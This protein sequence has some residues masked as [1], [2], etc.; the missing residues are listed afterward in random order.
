MQIVLN[1]V[2]RMPKCFFVKKSTQARIANHRCEGVLGFRQMLR[3]RRARSASRA[4]YLVLQ[5]RNLNFRVHTDK[6]SIQIQKTIFNDVCFQFFVYL[7]ERRRRRRDRWTN[8]LG[9]FGWRGTASP[10]LFFLLRKTWQKF[11]F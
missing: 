7:Q 1:C 11:L 4:L 2:K 9:A 6:N 8:C 5:N 3:T 10:N